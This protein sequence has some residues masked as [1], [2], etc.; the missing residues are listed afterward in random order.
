MASD[1]IFVSNMRSLSKLLA[2]SALGV[3]SAG[4]AISQQA[5]NQQEATN[6]AIQE[7]YEKHDAK[8]RGLLPPY[9]GPPLVLDVYQKSLQDGLCDPQQ[10]TAWETL[11]NGS[12]G[13]SPIADLG[14][15]KA[16]DSTATTMVTIDTFAPIY[17]LPAKL[18]FAVVIAKPVAGKVCIPES[19]RYVYVKLTL[20]VLKQFKPTKSDNKHMHETAQLTA[21]DFG[22]T[23]RFPSGYLETF[24]LSQE[25]FVE[26][27]KEYVLFMWKPVPSDDM[28]IISQAYLIQDGFVFPVSSN[29]DAERVYTKMPLLEF[30]AKV[31]AA[32]AQ[33]IDADVIG[34]PKAQR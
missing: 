3:L 16:L 7:A 32:V 21:V 34:N 30:E 26:I 20:E 1:C 13:S 25:G 27:G 29:G 31:K 14:F 28:L 8:V 4:L 6:H 11:F 12:M 5:A 33:N 15:S 10:H 2:F 18:A 22:G 9:S 24:L 23:I 17:S 19:R